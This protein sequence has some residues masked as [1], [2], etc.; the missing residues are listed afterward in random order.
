MRLRMPA[1]LLLLLLSALE[2]AAA[3]A[4]LIYLYIMTVFTEL[5]HYL[6]SVRAGP[7]RVPLQGSRV[8]LII[9]I[10]SLSLYIY[11]YIYIQIYT[12]ICIYI[13]IDNTSL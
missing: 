6:S 10:L 12:H 8:G 9:A 3:V 13:Y 5:T 4:A 1:G 2:G 7:D 11:I